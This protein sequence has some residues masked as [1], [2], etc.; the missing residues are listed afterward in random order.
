MRFRSSAI[1]AK[2]VVARRAGGAN[3]VVCEAPQARVWPAP[4][5]AVILSSCGISASVSRKTQS[6][7]GANLYHGDSEM[8]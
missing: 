7:A 8:P 3:S 1:G 5:Q 4:V 6:V 2:L